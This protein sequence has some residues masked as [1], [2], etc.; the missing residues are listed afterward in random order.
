MLGHQLENNLRRALL[1]RF[2][3]SLIYSVEANTIV[4]VAVAASESTESSEDT[5]EKGP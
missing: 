2:P 5:H 3:F 1:R 4:I